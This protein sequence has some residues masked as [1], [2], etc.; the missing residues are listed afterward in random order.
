MRQGLRHQ[1]ALALRYLSDRCDWWQERRAGEKHIFL[2][3]DMEAV[4]TLFMLV[5]NLPFFI[6]CI[7][8]FFTTFFALLL[9]LLM[10]PFILSARLCICKGRVSAWRCL[11]FIPYWKI[12]LPKP[13]RFDLY[14]AYEDP[15]PSGV[16]FD[17]GDEAYRYVHFGSANSAHALYAA[18]K[19]ALL[20]QGWTEGRF[21]CVLQSTEEKKRPPPTVR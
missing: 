16:A 12:R 13:A 5:L 18:I 11:L 8:H 19:A 3:V 2:V 21:G 20:A 4:F 10:S 1:A 15:A 17:A 6:G 9:A 14:E 7:E